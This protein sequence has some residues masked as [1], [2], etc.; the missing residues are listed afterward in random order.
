METQENTLSNKQKETIKASLSKYQEPKTANDIYLENK[1]KFNSVEISSLQKLVALLQKADYI[2]VLK[3]YK[4]T[5][6][7]LDKVEN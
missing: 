5:R 2:K 3:D 6:Y 4:P 1:T 7:A